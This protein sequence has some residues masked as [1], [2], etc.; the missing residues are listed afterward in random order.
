MGKGVGNTP[1]VHNSLHVPLSEGNTISSLPVTGWCSGYEIS[2]LKR[3]GDEVTFR[4]HGER[5]DLKEEDQALVFLGINDI[6][7][8]KIKTA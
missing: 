1:S 8:G 2:I 4:R 7:C 6:F 3:Y 5:T